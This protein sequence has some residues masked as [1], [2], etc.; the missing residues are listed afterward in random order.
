MARW[1]A[2][3]FLVLLALGRA[4]P[5]PGYYDRA[6]DLS[7]GPLKVALHEIVRGHVVIPYSQL[8]GPLARL[9]EDPANP[10]NVIFL[11]SADSVAKGTDFN[12][13]LWN[14]E[15]AWPRSRGNSDETGADDSDLHYI[16]PCYDAVNSTR[17]N[18]PFDLS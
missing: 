9:H 2:L 5:P 4:A 15:H 14:R 16:W 13:A 17:G 3:A 12:T 18:L 8:H 7:G 10:N 11:Y 1:I 6:A